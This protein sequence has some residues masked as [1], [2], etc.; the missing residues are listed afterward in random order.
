MQDGAEL[1]LST[2]N[3]CDYFI[4]SFLAAPTEFLGQP[5]TTN[6]EMMR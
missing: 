2:S 3:T 4:Y 1:G 5:C 6:T